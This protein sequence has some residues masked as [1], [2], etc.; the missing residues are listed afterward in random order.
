MN[1]KY[2]KLYQSK[3]IELSPE[4]ALIVEVT[5]GRSNNV[6]SL[7][8]M[9]RDDNG[10]W[11]YTGTRNGAKN[12]RIPMSAPAID[13]ISDEMAKVK[14]LHAK[15]EKAAKAKATVAQT[16]A[17]PGELPDLSDPAIVAQFAAFIQSMKAT[18]GGTSKKTTRKKADK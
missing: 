16:I 11:A 13:F 15:L 6:M 4:S 18:T 3:I 8:L 1:E 7:W 2:P 5:K 10:E 12:I 14:E 17:E 9:Y